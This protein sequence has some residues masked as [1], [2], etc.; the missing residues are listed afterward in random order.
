MP[1]HDDQP[2]AHSTLGRTQDAQ[3]NS[4]TCLRRDLSNS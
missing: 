4:Y 2:D 3:D 1:N